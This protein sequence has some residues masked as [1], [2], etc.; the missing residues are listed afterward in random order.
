MILDALQ[1]ILDT[2]RLD[3]SLPIA[4]AIVGGARQRHQVPARDHVHVPSQS[5]PSYPALEVDGK[6]PVIG[7]DQD[8]GGDVRPPVE[9]ERLPEGDVI[10]RPT[11]RPARRKDLRGDVMQEVLLHVEVR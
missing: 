10:L 11:L 6:E 8:A 2:P 4:P 3:P 9:G 7:C 5:R 1:L